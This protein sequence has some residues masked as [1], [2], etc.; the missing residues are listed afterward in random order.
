MNKTNEFV[1]KKENYKSYEEFERALG[2]IVLS[3][4][5][6][7][8]IMTVRY[9]EPGVGIV[10][11]DYNYAD[12]AFGYDYPYWLSEDEFFSIYADEERERDRELQNM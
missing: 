9:D 4:I 12:K 8:Y 3:L 2:R 10:A 6:S 11:I 5:E 7:D 1:L